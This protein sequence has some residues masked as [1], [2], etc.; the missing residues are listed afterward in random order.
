MTKIQEIP[1]GDWRQR[2][3]DWVHHY[4]CLPIEKFT[5]TERGLRELYQEGE[6]AEDAAKQII[7][8]DGGVRC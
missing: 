2:V 5:V 7:A 3:I 4:T 6:G 1:Y 8:Y